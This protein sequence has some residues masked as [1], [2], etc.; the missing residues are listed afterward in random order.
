MFFPA[1]FKAADSDCRYALRK[2]I[3]RQFCPFL[4]RPRGWGEPRWMSRW[5][6]SIHVEIRLQVRRLFLRA[7][8]LAT[9]E[10]EN[11]QNRRNTA[12]VCRNT[13]QS[14]FHAW[15]FVRQGL[16]MFAHAPQPVNFS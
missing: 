2:R 12:N 7:A 10:C 11:V 14:I 13:H 8:S 16:N 15:M 3:G 1:L 6:N 9:D 5:R 4:K